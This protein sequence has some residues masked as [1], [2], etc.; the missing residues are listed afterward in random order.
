MYYLW[1][2]DETGKAISKRVEINSI[3][4][5]PPVCTWSGNTNIN[6]NSTG[7]II[8]TCADNEIRVDKSTG[9]IN[10]SNITLSNS[11]IT[12][13]NIN[14]EEIN[15]GYKYTLTIKSGSTLGSTTMTVPSNIIKNTMSLGNEESS[16]IVTIADYYTISYKDVGNTD[17][18]GVSKEYSENYTNGTTYYGCIKLTDKAGNIAYLSSVGIKYSYININNMY[19]TSGEQIFTVPVTGTYKLEVWG[20]QGGGTNGGYGAYSVGSIKLNKDQKLYINVGGNTSTGTGGYNG[21]GSVVENVYGGGGATHIATV[22]G[23]LSTLS[24]K[25]SNILIVAGGGG[26]GNSYAGGG[27]GGISGVNGVGDDKGTGGTQTA[28]GTS[29][30]SGSGGSMGGGT[31]AFGIG[32][33]GDWYSESLGGGGGGYYGGGSGGGNGGNGG[34]GGSTYFNYSSAGYKGMGGAGGGISGV[35]GYRNTVGTETSTPGTQSSGYAF[36]KGNDNSSNTDSITT[37]PGGGSGYYG[38]GVKL[39]SGGAG[40]SGYIGNTLL[41]NKTMYCYNCTASSDTNT[42]TVSTTCANVIATENCSKQ[43]SGYVKITY[44]G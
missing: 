29:V 35:S 43:G 20:A 32:G 30:A 18:T 27:G 16:T 28:G 2:K 37:M 22:S 5:T 39:T 31:G 21:G 6:T 4:N 42:K 23:L 33:T 7:T 9:T 25:T 3:D 41:T 1:I 14:R 11:N 24:S 15:N 10:I 34:G 38:G 36:G 40:G 8:L 12:I 26:E 13:S 17:Q 44:L 19:S